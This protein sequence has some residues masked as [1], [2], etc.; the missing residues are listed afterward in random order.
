MLR[1][2]EYLYGLS[3]SG[4]ACN[5]KLKKAIFKL[6]TMGTMTGGQATYILQAKPPDRTV[7]KAAGTKRVTF[8][9]TTVINNE[10]SP[11]YKAEPAKKTGA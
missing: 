8:G 9:H 5:S 6:L 4:D 7:K 11:Y 1:V 3:E 10:E 2:L